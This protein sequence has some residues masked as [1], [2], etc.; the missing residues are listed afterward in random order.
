MILPDFCEV[1]P[2]HGAGSL[3]GRAIGAKRT[4]TI[5]YEKK[6]NAAL[7]MS[8]RTA[9]IS[10]LT[11]NMPAAPDH[12]SRCSDINRTGPALTGSLP[13]L[14]QLSPREFNGKVNENKFTVLDV[15]SYD[16]F[17]SQFISGSYHNDIYGNFAIFAGWL[18]PAEKDI[19]LVVNNEVEVREAI[20]GLRRVGLDHVTG[21]L[22]GGLFEWAIEGLS[23]EHIPQ[24]SAEEVYRMI[25]KEQGLLLLDVRTPAEYE[26]FHIEGSFHIPVPDLRKRYRELDAG[27]KTVVICST[28]RRSSMAAGILKQ[29]GF[30]N[31]YNAAG[32]I[33]GYH[34][35]GYGP[36]CPVCTI[37]H[38]PRIIN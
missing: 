1:Y 29:H 36:K 19:L 20:T 38:G 34:A 33:T 8:N 27:N 14:I 9:F 12:F 31:V 25:N 30:R 35:A 22:D 6:Y 15:R 7:R 16:V 13:E 32:G 4:S 23:T 2:A 17:G 21:Y 37:P 11:T 10:S 18:L 3:C 28:G 5:G 24:L 26:R